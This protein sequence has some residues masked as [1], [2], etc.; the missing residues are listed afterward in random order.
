MNLDQ[1]KQLVQNYGGNKIYY[2]KLAPNDNSKNQVYLGNSFDVL[3]IFPITE[4]V[5]D[6][7]GDWKKERF[8][9]TINYF[10]ITEEGKLIKAPKS[11]LILYP[12]YPEVRFSGFLAG[13][14]DAPSNLM[15]QRLQDRILFFS[16]TSDG[17]IIGY[18]AHPESDISKAINKIEHS[19]ESFNIFRVLD[20]EPNTKEKLIYELTRIHKLGWIPS[21]RLD[22]NKNILPCKSPNCG[23]YTLEAELGISPNGYAEPDYLGWE[24]K[25]FGVSSFEKLY[26]SVITLMTP[27]PNGGYY[28]TEG[29]EK[30]ISKYGYKDLKGREDRFNFGGIHKVGKLHPRTGLQMVLIGFDELTGKIRNTEGRITLIDKNEIEVASWSFSSMLKHWNKKHNQACYV[31]SKSLKDP[32][33]KYWYGNNLILG[34]GTDFQLFL[35]QLHAGN[36]FYDPGIK[37]EKI[38]TPSIKRRSQFRINSKN[39]KNLYKVNEIIDINN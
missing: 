20:I 38:K 6:S 26:S 25:Q 17:N 36:I 28:C 31:P 33:R 11:Q 39:L 22:R 30:F 23:G 13:C 7:S 4:I 5:S 14:K 12:K 10:W 15:T 8:K 37:L 1:L 21:K 18:V 9:A 29:V 19:L 3:N 24:I 16:V 2:K 32:E 34:T 35:I 27:E